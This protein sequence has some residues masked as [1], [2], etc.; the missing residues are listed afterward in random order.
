MIPLSGICTENMQQL[1]TEHGPI[2]MKTIATLCLLKSKFSVN[3]HFW[4]FCVILNGHFCVI[5]SSQIL[6]MM[7]STGPQ[8]MYSEDIF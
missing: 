4:T 1:M 5:L 2:M 7:Q 6:L 8:D 3:S